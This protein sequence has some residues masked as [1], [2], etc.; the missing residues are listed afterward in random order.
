MLAAATICRDFWLR[1]ASAAGQAPDS[2]GVS[3]C[4]D[5]VV[6]EQHLEEAVAPDVGQLHI[7][8]VAGVVHE[9]VDELPPLKGLHQHLGRHQG[10]QRLGEAQVA[11]QPAARSGER[12]ARMLDLQGRTRFQMAS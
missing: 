11:P 6:V 4:M 12:L 3:T 8:G 5:E 1:G 9:A 2:K 10:P 7:V